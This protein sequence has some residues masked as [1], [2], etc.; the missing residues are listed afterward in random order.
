MNPLLLL[1]AD[2]QPYIGR[3]VG[4]WEYIWTAYILTWTVLLVY[5]LNLA[6][7]RR[8]DHALLLRGISYVA[9]GVGLMALLLANHSPM[10]YRALPV[11]PWGLGA[12]YVFRQFSMERRT[13]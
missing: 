2:A 1:A 9:T 6:G 13:P 10:L 7:R 8:P 11:I 12:F 4:G 5:G 3:I